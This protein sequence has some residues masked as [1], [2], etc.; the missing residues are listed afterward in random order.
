MWLP[1]VIAKLH[2]QTFT[3]RALTG[4]EALSH[5]CTCIKAKKVLVVTMHRLFI[6][7]VRLSRV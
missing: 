2:G 7:S 5:C 4:M 6:H 1:F 3:T